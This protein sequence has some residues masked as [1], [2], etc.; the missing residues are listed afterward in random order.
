MGKRMSMSINMN[1][2]E[3]IEINDKISFG[4]WVRE[5]PW[6]WLLNQTDRFLDAIA[7]LSSK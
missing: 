7:L 3:Y 1:S 4:T 2:S 5:T 6:R